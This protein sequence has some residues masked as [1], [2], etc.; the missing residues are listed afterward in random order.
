MTSASTPVASVATSCASTA[1][2]WNVELTLPSARSWT[3]VWRTDVSV[4]S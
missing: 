1:A 2:T 3:S 4:T